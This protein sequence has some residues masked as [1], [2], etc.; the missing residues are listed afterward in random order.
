MESFARKQRVSRGFTLIELLVVVAIIAILA[1]ILFPVF[2]R[3]REN[4]RRTSCAS[5]LKQIG[6]IVMQYSQD[7][8][9]KMPPSMNKAADNSDTPWQ[10]LVQPYA[11]STDLF[12]CPSNTTPKSSTIYGSIN[13]MTESGVRRSYI[14]N[15]GIETAGG[16]TPKR[17][18]GG[19]RPWQDQRNINA[20][21]VISLASLVQ[22]A[23]TIS[24]TE[25]RGI[26]NSDATVQWM[27]CLMDPTRTFTDHLGTANFLFLD[28]HVKALHPTATATP[29]INMWT[30]DNQTSLPSVAPGA[31]AVLQTT[32]AK[33]E[34]A[35]SVS[36]P[37]LGCDAY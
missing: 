28:G 21:V 10:S 18:T 33:A 3:A 14:A 24:V 35:M 17:G 22:P 5:N 36:G 13:S 7:F 25:T 8:D 20:L 15:G 23:T 29:T 9:E 11:K 32:M 27:S 12:R 31:P 16:T 30:N 34:L 37:S 26:N 4:A 2:A 19:L 1:S 6:L